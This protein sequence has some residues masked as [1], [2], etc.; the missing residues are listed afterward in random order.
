[1]KSWGYYWTTDECDMEDKELSVELMYTTGDGGV[2]LD[3][4]YRNSQHAVRPV[5]GQ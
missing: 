5:L 2:K 1:M 4:D 3:S